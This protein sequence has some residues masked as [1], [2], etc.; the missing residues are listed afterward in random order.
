MV[1]E[2]VW[3]LPFEIE[4]TPGGPQRLNPLWDSSMTIQR[5]I[6]MTIRLSPT[7]TLS[8]DS[9]RVSFSGPST[10]DLISCLDVGKVELV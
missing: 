2:V 3:S 10:A 8:M 5:C 7:F 1:W 4:W 6:L 9:S